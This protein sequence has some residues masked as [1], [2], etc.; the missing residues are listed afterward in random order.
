M[1]KKFVLIFA[2][3]LAIL[4]TSTLADDVLQL[5]FNPSPQN[6]TFPAEIQSGQDILKLYV[7]GVQENHIPVQAGTLH[8]LPFRYIQSPVTLAQAVPQPDKRDSKEGLIHSIMEAQRKGIQ[9]A[10]D[11]ASLM[12]SNVEKERVQL[13]QS[14]IDKNTVSY[15]MSRIDNTVK[16]IIDAK[17]RA[18]FKI[19]SKAQNFLKTVTGAGMKA[20]DKVMDKIGFGHY[21]SGVSEVEAEPTEVVEINP[22][23]IEENL[24]DLDEFNKKLGA[25]SLEQPA[26]I[27]GEL[28]DRIVKRE[29]GL[30]HHVQEIIATGLIVRE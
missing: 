13:L 2:I 30:G 23:T 3:S 28:L 16:S 15:L 12:V 11:I 17:L 26:K 18:I 5:A 14:M 4:A 25:A 20:A 1:L 24:N 19:K 27:S 6:L 21:R 10:S 29:P 7:T 8:P 9:R 22:K